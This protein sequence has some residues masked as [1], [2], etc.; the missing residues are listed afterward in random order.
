[1]DEFNHKKM[2]DKKISK[3]CEIWNLI[4]PFNMDLFGDR[5]VLQKKVFLLKK[6]GFD[7]GYEFHPYIRGPYCNELATDGYKIRDV[8][9]ITGDDPCSNKSLNVLSELSKNHENDI[10]WFEMLASLVYLFNENKS[11]SKKEL[12]KKLFEHKPHLSDE[13]MFEEAYNILKLKGLLN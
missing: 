4:G 5:L 6:L 1:M 11:I 13:E 3:L 8:I 10:Y 2:T 9:K 12:K 7:L